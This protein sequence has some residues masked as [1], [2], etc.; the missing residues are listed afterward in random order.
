MT[1]VPH[2][3]TNVLQMA[4]DAYNQACR[5]ADEATADYDET[6]DQEYFIR[7]TSDHI[8]VQIAADRMN[9]ANERRS[10]AYNRLQLAYRMV[11][12]APVS[13]PNNSIALQTC[14]NFGG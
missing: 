4:K 14:D 10:A 1:I 3:R 6:V 13:Y 9:R 8:R 2:S 7:Q 12:A 11:G 5:V